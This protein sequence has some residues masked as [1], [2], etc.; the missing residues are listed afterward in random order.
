MDFVDILKFDIG[1]IRGEDT[2]EDEQMEIKVYEINPLIPPAEEV[3]FV[4]VVITIILLSI[5]LFGSI[6]N[7]KNKK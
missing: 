1:W 7:Y 5:A 4:G 3:S 6:K 2:K